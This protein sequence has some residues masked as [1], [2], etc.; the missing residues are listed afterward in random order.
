[1]K[2]TKMQG[3]GNDFIMID[4][5][6]EK[7]NNINEIVPKLCDRHFSIG[8]DGVILVR[9][10][11]VGDIKMVIINSDGSLAG[12][13]GNGIRCFSKYIWE[14]DIVKKEEIS[15]ETGDG[16]KIA[17]LVSHEDKVISVSINMGYPKFEPKLI[18]A[19]CDESIINKNVCVEGKKYSIT[20][21]LMG[22]PHT[23]LFGKLCE[24][25]VNE[26]KY[27]E[28]NELFPQGTNVDFAEIVNRNEV[29]VVTWER[30]AGA[31]LACGTGCTAT[32]AAGNKLNLLDNIVKVNVPGGELL[33]EI[34]DGLAFMTGSAEISF[35]GV[36]EV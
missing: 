19:N 15:V 3:C 29:N 28:K 13:C 23:V 22:V 18:P 5:I 27:I 31:T 7:L 16:I 6:N 26:G 36:C 1:M 10:S 25:D 24:F 21:L 33:V 20:S 8:A 2:F 17:K 32:V 11:T 4:D 12:M 35:E 34:K 9:K 30:G 14:K